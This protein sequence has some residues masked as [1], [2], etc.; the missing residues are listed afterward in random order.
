[1]FSLM[2]LSVRVGVFILAMAAVAKGYDMLDC[3]K[4]F[5][6]VTREFVEGQLMDR[7]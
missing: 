3:M 7:A 4:N 2:A 5:C 1:M 6:I